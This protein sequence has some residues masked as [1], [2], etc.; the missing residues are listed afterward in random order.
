[1]LGTELATAERT[2]DERAEGI[3]G[4]ARGCLSAFVTAEGQLELLELHRHG[5]G[6]GNYGAAST[7]WRTGPVRPSL[8]VGGMLARP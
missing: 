3:A 7:G 8:H 4:D 5:H 1:M 6:R 2:A